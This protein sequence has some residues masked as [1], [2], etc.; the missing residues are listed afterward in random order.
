MAKTSYLV[1]RE[2]RNFSDENIRN[3]HKEAEMQ[4]VHLS[5][6]YPFIPYSLN[7]YYVLG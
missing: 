3:K 4:T 6:S 2:E 5:G 1:R 7:T